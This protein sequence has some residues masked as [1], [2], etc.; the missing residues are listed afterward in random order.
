M[1]SFDLD[2]LRRGH[3]DHDAAA[4]TSLYTDDAVI[5][6]IDVTAPPSNPR[7]LE[8]IAAIR[9]YY[10]DVCSR[11][12]VHQIEDAFTDGDHLAFR[13]ACEYDNGQRVLTSE[14]CE[15]QSGRIAHETLVQAWDD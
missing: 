3:T 5:E 14:M 9:D 11:D 7:R 2:T 12:M 6:I 15:L 8:G 13:V 4:L 1:A 10:D